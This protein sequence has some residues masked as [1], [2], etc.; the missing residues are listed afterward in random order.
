MKQ[1]ARKL[2]DSLHVQSSILCVP[3]LIHLI[4]AFVYVLF[5]CV[6]LCD[7]S[8]LVESVVS[9]DLSINCT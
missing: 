2:I 7:L 3:G 5:I 6:L 8:G 4:S 1:S 9:I